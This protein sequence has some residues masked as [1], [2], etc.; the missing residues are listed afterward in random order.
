MK[1]STLNPFNQVT[2]IHRRIKEA[3]E[4]KQQAAKE[5]RA[6]NSILAYLKWLHG[7][8]WAI[9]SKFEKYDCFRRTV[10]IRKARGKDVPRFNPFLPNAKESKPLGATALELYN[11]N[12]ERNLP[13]HIIINILA[14]RLSSVKADSHYHCVL[15]CEQVSLHL[16]G[17]ERHALVR[18]VFPVKLANKYNEQVELHGATC[19]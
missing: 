19:S 5:S 10:A 9:M 18:M 8:D 3:H 13:R 12:V 15:E 14:N 6:A 16:T 7:D 4:R 11:I 1:L 17:G 2:G